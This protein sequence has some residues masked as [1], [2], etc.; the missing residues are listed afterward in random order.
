MSNLYGN[1]HSASQSSLT[2]SKRVGDTRLKVLQFFRANPDEFD[3]VFV[4]NATAGIKLVAEAFRDNEDGFW[5]GYHGDAHTSLVGVRELAT[6]GAKCFEEDRDVEHWLSD[7]ESNKGY[8]ES[9][10]R[11]FA[12]PGQSNMTGHRPPLEW[13]KRVQEIPCPGDAPIYTLL[14]A[15]SLVS[16]SPLD[17]SDAASSP[18]FIALS[19]YKIFGFPDLGALIVRKAAGDIL[20]QR[21]YFGGGTTDMII[22]IGEQWHAIKRHSLHSHLEDGTI[23]FHNII[24]LDCA[25]NTHQQMYGSMQAVSRHTSYLASRMYRRLSSMRHYNG[26]CVC[27]IYET[28]CHPTE[29]RTGRSP[30]IALNIRSALGEYV[31]AAEVEMLAAVKNIQMRSGGLCNPGGIARH[32]RLTS[33]QMRQNFANGQRCGKNDIILGGKPVS[34]L[35]V[36]FG[37]MSSIQD[38]DTFAQFLEEF[39]VEMFPAPDVARLPPTPPPATSSTLFTVESLSVFPI[40]SCGAFEIPPSMQWEVRP[41]GLA[42]DRKW[43]I[44]HQGTE[45]ALSQKRY[46]RMALIKPVVDLENGVLRVACESPERSL[47][48]I[49]ISLE[50]VDQENTLNTI[51]NGLK[52]LKVC[53]EDID[54]RIHDSP[55]IASFFTEFLQVPCTLARLPSTAPRKPAGMNKWLRFSTPDASMPGQYPSSPPPSPSHPSRVLFSNESPILLISRSSV[56][57]LNASIKEAAAEA[58][59][60]TP[61]TV[62]P[63]SFRG[64]IVISEAASPVTTDPSPYIEESWKHIA[65]HSQTSPHAL[66][67]TVTGPCQRCQMVCVDQIDGSRNPEPFATLAKTRRRLGRVWFGIHL[68]PEID[69]QVKMP[70]IAVG[71]VITTASE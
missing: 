16:T 31:P 63:F 52:N 27:E 54:V 65:I 49:E 38:V 41:D 11:L 45:M 18:D 70:R 9:C 48:N 5:Y 21:K 67:L 42:W 23:P 24:A 40:K 10:L 32:L 58:S 43:C 44:V 56:D 71:D 26:R 6:K 39:Y 34:V 15:A 36:S 25:L 30:N 37:A 69:R 19:F 68:Q 47:E 60:P 66:N 4:A 62:P 50:T 35:R 33:S 64:N 2:T 53:E 7:L 3:I 8:E 46:P 51:S 1:P 17:L 59:Q 14:D 12:F 29:N 55:K 22:S 13:C 20:R 28:P 57:S 61:K